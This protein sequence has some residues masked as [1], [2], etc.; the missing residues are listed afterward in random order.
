MPAELSHQ[1]EE[2]QARVAAA[3][4]AILARGSEDAERT[5]RLA[6]VKAERTVIF[7][8]L[9]SQQIGSDTAD[10]LVSELDQSGRQMLPTCSQRRNSNPPGPAPPLKKVNRGFIG[11]A[12]IKCRS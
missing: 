1:A 5:M 4:A 2:D 11:A 9:R 8:M 3:E 10:K 6:A 12:Q 7:Q